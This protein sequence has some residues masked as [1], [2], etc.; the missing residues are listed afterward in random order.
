MSILTTIR[1]GVTLMFT[2]LFGG[3]PW[4]ESLTMWG[5]ILIA[6]AKA[7]E[8]AGVLPSGT[9]AALVGLGDSLGPLLVV[10]GIRKAA[11]APD[12]G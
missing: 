10:L 5:L 8:T 3:K 1:K 11:T 6:M 9:E 7:A 4:F 12:V 2:N